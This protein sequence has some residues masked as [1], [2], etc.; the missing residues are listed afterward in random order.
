MRRRPYSV[1]LFDEIEKAHPDVFNT[2]LQILE[3]GRLTDGQGRTVDFKNTV[4]D[5]DQQHRQRMH[6][7]EG[8]RDDGEIEEGAQLAGA[9]RLLRAHFR[10]EFLNRIDETIL[11]KPLRLEEIERIVELLVDQL[12]GRLASRELRLEL[13]GDARSWIAR[14]G[15]DPVYGARP[16]KRF[17]QREVETKLGRALIAGEILDGA[18]IRLDVR[19]DE[20]VIEHDLTP[21]E[22]VA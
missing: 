7:L 20:L 3:D 15:F 10:P 2:L 22:V 8:V 11:F 12:R 18:A 16:L 1:V 6:L 14:R 4:L 5:H 13:S 21:A 17:L 9:P 19:D